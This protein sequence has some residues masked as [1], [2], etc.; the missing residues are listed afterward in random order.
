MK[1]KKQPKV[2]TLEENIEAYEA[3]QEEMEKYYMG[4]YVVF[5]NREKID[6]FDSFDSFEAAAEEAILRFGA[7]PYLIRQVGRKV[8]HLPASIMFAPVS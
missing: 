2:A 7:E 1:T 5:Y 8:I 3:R 6:S 4:K